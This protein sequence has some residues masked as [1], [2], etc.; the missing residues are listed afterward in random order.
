MAVLYGVIMFG[1]GYASA[2]VN[3]TTGVQWW[4]AMAVIL[5]VATV[6]GHI[7]EKYLE[8]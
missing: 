4:V 2:H 5:A 6:A 3:D 1:L 8:R 7:R